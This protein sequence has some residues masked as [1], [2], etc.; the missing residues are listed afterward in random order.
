ML[1]MNTDYNLSFSEHSEKRVWFLLANSAYKL[2][3]FFFAEGIEMEIFDTNNILWSKLLS[4]ERTMLKLEAP[5]LLK[6]YPTF[7]LLYVWI[8][9]F[10]KVI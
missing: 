4:S 7:H 3:I 10:F 1:S 5:F 2:F 8:N 9:P 6:D